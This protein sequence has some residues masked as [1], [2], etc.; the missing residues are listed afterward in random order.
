MT[1]SLTIKA[2]VD[3]SSTDAAIMNVQEFPTRAIVGGALL[4][5]M[6]TIVALSY[7]FQ[8]HAD[9]EQPLGYFLPFSLAF[10][11][12][13]LL[14]LATFSVSSLASA[15]SSP[16]LARS[17]GLGFMSVSLSL[18]VY[19]W[20]PNLP[21]SAP[22]AVGALL[23]GSAASVGFRLVRPAT[24]VVLILGL[25][26]QSFLSLS[27]PLDVGAANMLP[28]IGA[29]CELVLQ[30]DNPYLATFPGIA[31]E[32]L[33]YLPGLVLPYCIPV[34]ADVDM[35]LVNVILVA[36]I[37]AYSCWIFRSWSRPERLSLG[38]WPLLL[39][40]PTAQM[41]IH[42]HVWPYWLLVL[43][44]VHALATRRFLVAALLLGVML[45]TR[46]MSLFLAA[47]AAAFMSTR[48]RPVELARYAAVTIAAYLVIMAPV[49][50]S[51]PGW[52]DRFYLGLTDIGQKLHLTYGNP[53]NQVS[54]S[55]FLT[56]AGFAGALPF[57]QAAILL[58]AVAV[59]WIWRTR[60]T[61]DRAVMLLGVGY[62]LIIGLNP[63][64]HRYF[65]FP[66]LILIAL[67]IGFTLTGPLAVARET[68]RTG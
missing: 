57:L 27:V 14:I 34:A 4:F 61:F 5:C 20:A 55:G 17:L 22:I 50:L 6:T 49:I 29:G 60:I 65:Y 39:S 52:I 66:G 54:L 67:A 19:F 24:A 38:L 62:I 11:S 13:L 48:L 30:A 47:P 68:R 51:T 33:I 42:G 16:E 18:T 59:F 56:A 36:A 37:V 46:Q 8:Y 35:R 2:R 26:V 58:L 23:V 7:G 63:F 31:S 12:C 25:L 43:I 15:M 32:P 41:M 40:S 64:L 45:A 9:A 28:I 1:T 3:G 10:F 44:F 21:I 53:M